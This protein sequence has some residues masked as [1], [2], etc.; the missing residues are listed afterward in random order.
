MCQKKTKKRKIFNS[1]VASHMLCPSFALSY[2][3]NVKT[4]QKMFSV[5]SNIDYIIFYSLL[6][7]ELS[8]IDYFFTFLGIDSQP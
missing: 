5:I 7:G 8:N 6:F 2:R 1:K 4:L 3:M